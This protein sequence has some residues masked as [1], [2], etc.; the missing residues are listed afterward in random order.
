MKQFVKNGEI[1]HIGGQVPMKIDVLENLK[2]NIYIFNEDETF[3]KTIQENIKIQ[4][5]DLM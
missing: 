1:N 3:L 5:I 4:L 2:T